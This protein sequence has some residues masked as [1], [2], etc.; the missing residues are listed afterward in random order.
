[1]LSRVNMIGGMASECC[2]AGV[3]DPT[4]SAV[5]VNVALNAGA[6]KRRP[7][8]FPPYKSRNPALPAFPSFYHFPSVPGIH[9]L[10]HPLPLFVPFVSRCNMPCPLSS[11]FYYLIFS[12]GNYTIWWWWWWW[13][14]IMD[15]IWK[16]IHLTVLETNLNLFSQNTTWFL[17]AIFQHE[18]EIETVFNSLVFLQDYNMKSCE[19]FCDGSSW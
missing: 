6:W 16:M 8:H 12:L 15:M 10:C 2:V 3:R 19:K 18:L 14:Y 11:K 17:I 1:M 13:L 9:P 5:K 7:V 4:A